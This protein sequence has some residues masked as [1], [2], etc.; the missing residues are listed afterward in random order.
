MKKLPKCF[1]LSFDIEAADGICRGC[2][3][4][5][6]CSRSYE[7]RT[8]ENPPAEP[9]LPAA[10]ADS[11]EVEEELEPFEYLLA[12]LGGKYEREDRPG[13]VTDAYFFTH[14]GHVRAQV[15]VARKTGRVKLKTRSFERILD[16]T[17]AVETVEE[18]E[19]L[20]RKMIKG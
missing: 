1:G 16:S 4:N 19:E 11:G 15:V 5:V 2:A 7:N 14:N 8:G 18:A 12:S 9:D 10:E 17:E 3:A 6:L 13:T 20:F